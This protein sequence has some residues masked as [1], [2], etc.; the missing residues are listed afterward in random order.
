MRRHPH[1]RS[2]GRFHLKAGQSEERAGGGAAPTPATVRSPPAE[3]RLVALPGMPLV[4]AGD[5][6]PAL[7]IEAAGRCG[8]IL[9]DGDVLVVA[10]KIVSK[11]EGRMVSL[12]TVQP[13]S[14]AIDLAKETAK[15]P[16]F[17]EVVLRESLEVVRYA[18][19]VLIVAHKLGFVMAN[20]GVDQSNVAPE[21][22]DVV[23]LLPEDPDASCD[24]LR[25]DIKA[26][27][28]VDVAVIIND[29]HGRPWRIGSVG[30]ALG[31]SGLPAVMDLRG[32]ADLFE[33]TLRITEVG[34]ADELA[35]AASLMM[36]QADEARPVVLLRG[37]PYPR[38]EGRAG[39]LARP[40][41]RDLFRKQS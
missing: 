40:R 8:E 10:Q 23:L 2:A 17:V 14:R 35:S 9:R 22:A 24:K 12:A 36:G 20:A 6:L 34:F 25:R 16:R 15:D 28:G 27:V 38:R 18:R 32:R 19:D 5:D 11:A 1:H 3:L 29:S 21:S 41:D 33:R 13:S 26:R 31:V 39:E 37:V 4:R 7:I 30:V